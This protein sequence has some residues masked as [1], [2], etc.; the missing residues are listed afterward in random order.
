V[1]NPPNPGLGPIK[2]THYSLGFDQTIPGI[3]DFS[4]TTF[5]KKINEQV[6]ES[7]MPGAT[8]VVYTTYQNGIEIDSKGFT[9]DIRFQKINRIHVEANYT[10]Q[11]VIENRPDPYFRVGVASANPMFINT[12]YIAPS[13]Y[14]QRHTVN[15]FTHI[16]TLSKDGPEIL[17]MYP[18]GNFGVGLRY[19]FGS[20][21]KY[22]P[23]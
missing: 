14:D 20:G 16:H 8:P 21:F 11:W 12:P 19:T 3:L 6:Y 22:T 2:T 7:W 23:N 9:F 5:V 13:Y 18:L 1:F 10:L 15:L 17:G 4:L